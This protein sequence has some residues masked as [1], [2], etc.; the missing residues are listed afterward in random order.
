MENLCERHPALTFPSCG[1]NVG[2]EEPLFQEDTGASRFL[3][4]VFDA[5]NA[6][7]SQ[8]LLFKR[9]VQAAVPPE[10]GGGL[11]CVLTSARRRPLELL[12]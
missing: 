3:R 4:L 11:R 12:N 7:P 5:G 8:P 1:L 6:A 10:G 9:L 2:A